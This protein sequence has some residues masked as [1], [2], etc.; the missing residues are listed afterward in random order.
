M[1]KHVKHLVVWKHSGVGLDI[2]QTLYSIVF[3]IC[4]LYIISLKPQ[5]IDV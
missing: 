5:A 1:Y 3:I 2:K 4:S